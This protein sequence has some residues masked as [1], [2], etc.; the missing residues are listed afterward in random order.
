MTNIERDRN[1]ATDAIR[2]VIDRQITCGFDVVA[3][4]CEVH[5]TSYETVQ[6]RCYILR[7]FSSTNIQYSILLY[8]AE[9]DVMRHV[10]FWLTSINV[11]VPASFMNDFESYMTWGGIKFTKPRKRTV[12]RNVVENLSLLFPEPRTRKIEVLLT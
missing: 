11:G 6:C 3:M 1:V 9:S 4:A 12:V 8:D 2:T 5:D 10:T 7:L